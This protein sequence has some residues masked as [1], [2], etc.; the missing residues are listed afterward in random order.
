MYIYEIN[1]LRKI[2]QVFN[3]KKKKQ[4]LLPGMEAVTQADLKFTHNVVQI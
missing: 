4:I 1:G 3:K 2:I